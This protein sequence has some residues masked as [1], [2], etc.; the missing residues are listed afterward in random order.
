[1]STMSTI[2]RKDI[3]KEST[4]LGCKLPPSLGIAATAN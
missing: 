1:M 3:V 2:G 4:E